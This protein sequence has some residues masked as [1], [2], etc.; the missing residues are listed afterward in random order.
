[1]QNRKKSTEAW[2][3]GLVLITF[4][5]PYFIARKKYNL[6]E[7]KKKFWKT[8]KY[9]FLKGMYILA[10]VG[11]SSDPIIYFMLKNFLM[12]ILDTVTIIIAFKE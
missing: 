7:L 12:I 11:L 9:L 8:F 10:N 6:T 5:I 3:V 1:M 4:E 2:A